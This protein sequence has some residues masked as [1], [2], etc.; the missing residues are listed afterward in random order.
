VAHVELSWTESTIEPLQRTSQWN[1]VDRWSAVVD[2]ANEPCMVIDSY[3][4]IV[5]IS[6]AGS[7]FLGFSSP[8]V[9]IGACLFDRAL[10]LLDFTS[11]GGEL[12][13]DEIQRIPPILALTSGLLARGVLRV[14]SGGEVTT[15]DA[16]S[17]PL[18]DTDGVVGSLT[19]FC[20]V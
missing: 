10:P 20:V 18:I 11:E 2:N 4:N 6:D 12:S 8:R 1:S 7:K 16:V 14:R 13:A 19:F 9:A 5:A 3:G 15:M 17:T